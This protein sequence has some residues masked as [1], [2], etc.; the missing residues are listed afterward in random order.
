MIRQVVAR[1]RLRTP[2][3]LS[4]L[5]IMSAKECIRLIPRRLALL[6][7]AQIILHTA[8]PWWRRRQYGRTLDGQSA[9]LAKAYCRR[10]VVVRIGSVWCRRCNTDIGKADIEEEIDFGRCFYNLVIIEMT[11]SY[12]LLYS[13][14][15]TLYLPNHRYSSA[16][17][18]TNPPPTSISPTSPSSRYSLPPNNLCPQILKEPHRLPNW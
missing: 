5:L 6:L 9:C 16:C 7:A 18:I 1:D 8:V 10:C 3:A 17:P 12:K 15:R 4:H 11:R 14:M 13:L 2:L